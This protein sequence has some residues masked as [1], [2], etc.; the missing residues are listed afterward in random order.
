MGSVK[1]KI[2]GI[3]NINDAKYSIMSGANYIGFIFY[4][5]SPRY[6]EPSKVEKIILELKKEGLKFLSVAVFVNPEKE[7]VNKVIL[8]TKIDILQFHGEEAENFTLSFNKPVIKAFRV[9]DLVDIK[10]ALTFKSEF[11]LFDAFSNKGYGGTGDCFDW[12]ILEKISTNRSFFLSG[13][14]DGN[15]IKKA[16][17]QCLPYGVDLSSGVEL[18]PGVKSKKKI[19]YFFNMFNSVL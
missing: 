6:I 10:K 5:K 3:T 19:D 14:I 18:S 9:K 8:Q 15:N 16:I 2:C 1:V 17:Q 4:P 12:K 11:L 7:F 13:G